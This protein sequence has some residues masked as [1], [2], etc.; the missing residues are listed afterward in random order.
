M[1]R[2]Q[3][4]V[5]EQLAAVRAP[6]A[7]PALLAR[8]ATAPDWR[9]RIAVVEHPATPVET[10]R[11]IATAD[12]GGDEHTVLRELAFHPAADAVVLDR[13]LARARVMLAE[14]R[15]PY[16]V[17]IA[18]AERG[19]VPPDVAVELGRLPGASARLRRGL[20]RA[21]VRASRAVGEPA[22][23]GAGGAD[24]AGRAAGEPGAGGAGQESSA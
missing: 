15:R 14:G 17:V 2:E 19:V 20:R 8:L 11:A 7:D 3:Q 1:R 12:H 18:L 5:S 13:V 21:L 22:A 23:G 16:S 9:V 6:D 10:L 24:G 4:L